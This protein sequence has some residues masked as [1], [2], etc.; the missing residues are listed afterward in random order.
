MRPHLPQLPTTHQPV[1]ST[2]RAASDLSI[3]ETA[4]GGAH[5]LVA[6][7]R[8]L[9]TAREQFLSVSA[10]QA[11]ALVL[12]TGGWAL[13]AAIAIAAAA[14]Q[15]AL[16]CQIAALRGMRNEVCLQLVIQGGSSL[17]LPCIDR[18]CRGLRDNRRRDQLARSIDELVEQASRR[19]IMPGAARPLAYQHVVR[20]TAPE[21]RRVAAL[22]RGDSPGLRGVAMVKWIL[23]SPATP[24]Y[25]AE[26]EP[27]RRD[28]GRARYLMALDPSV[29]DRGD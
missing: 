3:A 10:A 15:L 13:G 1:V 27:L 25:G 29:A 12:W 22:T 20:A 5:P 7:L 16:G 8:R 6:A 19:Y 17:P 11:C 23:T 28:L 24:L 21:L 2:G 26:V 18:V 14:C 9:A 4:L